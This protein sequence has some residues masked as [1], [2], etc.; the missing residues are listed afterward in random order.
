LICIFCEW[1]RASSAATN[2]GKLDKADENLFVVNFEQFRNAVVSYLSQE[3]QLIYNSSSSWDEI[4]FKVAN[5]IDEI[6][7]ANA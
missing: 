2:K 3:D 5:F 1:G 4:K 7:R 6:R